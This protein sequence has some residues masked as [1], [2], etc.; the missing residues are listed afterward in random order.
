[1]LRVRMD[2]EDDPITEEVDAVLVAVE[3]HADTLKQVRTTAYVHRD[4]L[5][6]DK[7]GVVD[8]LEALCSK[9]GIEYSH[10]YD[11]P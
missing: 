5:E 6:R 9:Q 3:R 8:R 10:E 4:S 2:V 11:S 7:A 1:M